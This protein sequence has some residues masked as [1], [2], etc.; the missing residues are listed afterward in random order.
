VAV[1]V[2]PHIINSVEKSSAAQRW[3]P[4]SGLI[5]IV[6]LHSNLIILAN[7]LKGPVVIAIAASTEVRLAIDEVV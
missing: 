7:H 6:I 3:P 5:D 2:V 4:A 1:N